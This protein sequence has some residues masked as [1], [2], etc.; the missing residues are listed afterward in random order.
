MYHITNQNYIKECVLLYLYE[1]FKNVNKW[2]CLYIAILLVH[3]IKSMT[4]FNAG[5][6]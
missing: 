1:T 5:L 6:N 3:L 4:L 2:Q